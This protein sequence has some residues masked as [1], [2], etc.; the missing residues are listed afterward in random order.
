[1]SNASATRSGP[2]LLGE[3]W[4]SFWE[5]LPDLVVKRQI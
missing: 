4:W 5:Q 3:A 2:S 1:M